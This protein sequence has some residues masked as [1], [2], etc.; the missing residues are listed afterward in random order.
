MVSLARTTRASRGVGFSHLF[1]DDGGDVMIFDRLDLIGIN[2][3][4][5]KKLRPLARA[6]GKKVVREWVQR[7]LQRDIAQRAAADPQHYQH[8]AL[9]AEM[10]DRQPADVQNLLLR[11]SLVDRV[12]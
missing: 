12:N 3:V 5:Y 11:T 10:L 2:I 8:L 7:A 1:V 4:Q 6:V 9:V